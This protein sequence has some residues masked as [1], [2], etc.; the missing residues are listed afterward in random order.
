MGNKYLH[1]CFVP[2]LQSLLHKY[3]NGLSCHSD[4]III[5]SYTKTLLFFI[6]II[7]DQLFHIFSRR[8]ETE[9]QLNDHSMSVFTDFASSRLMCTPLFFP[10]ASYVD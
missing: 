8:L 9:K 6:S 7:H 1:K 5:N 3:F 4:C 2:I 10:S